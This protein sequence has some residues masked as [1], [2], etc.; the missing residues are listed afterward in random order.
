MRLFSFLRAWLATF[1]AFGIALA[2]MLASPSASAAI[3]FDPTPSTGGS[4]LT[5]M[6]IIQD[7]GNAALSGAYLGVKFSSNIA[8]TNVYARVTVGGAGYSLD[9]TEAQDHFIGDLSGTAKTSYWFINYPTSGNGTFTVQI[10]TGNPAAGGLLQGTSTT[11]TVSSA[12][13]DNSAAANKIVSVTLSPSSILL[14]Q[15][16]NA[17]VCYSVNSTARLLIEPAI[18]SGFDPNKLR[19][20]NVVVD[21]YGSADCTGTATSTLSNQL[22]FTSVSSNSVRGDLHVSGRRDWQRL[23]DAYRQRP[24]RYLQIQHGLRHSARRCGLHDSGP[25]Q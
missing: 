6:E 4:G 24:Q 15:N 12:N 18:T 14:G 20:G 9:A 1:V 23:A 3:T 22:L 11:Y 25:G 16:F 17:I 13:A 8:L 7:A 5:Q 2:L 19:L 21:A 10:Y